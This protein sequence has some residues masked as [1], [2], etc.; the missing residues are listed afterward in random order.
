MKD[1]QPQPPVVEEN[2]AHPPDSPILQIEDLT[3]AY[4][5]Q[6]VL[7]EVSLSLGSQQLVGLIGPNGAGKSTLIKAILGMVSFQGQVQ[8]GGASVARNRQLLSYVP[9]KEEVRWD[10]PVTVGDVVM[11]GRY[12]RLGWLRWPGRADRQVVEKVLEQVGMAEFKNRQISE[13]SGGQQQRVFVARALA[14]E[15]QIMLLDEPL[16]GI[17][18]TSQEIIMR[19]LLQLRDEGKLI[20]MATHDLRAAAEM[21]DACVMLNRRLIAF[22]PPATV[23]QPQ[24]LGATFGNKVLTIG[25]MD[26]EGRAATTMVLE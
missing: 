5:R 25:G 3:V 16:T 12:R 20:L 11:M 9:Q 8:V 22:G 10:F 6:V 23:F 18:T 24:I 21:C 26:M 14:Q 7:Q 15:G 13:L 19:L 17:D 2:L 4:G 1:L